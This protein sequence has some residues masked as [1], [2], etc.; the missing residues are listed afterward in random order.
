VASVDKVLGDQRD[1]QDWDVWSLVAKRDWTSAYRLVIRERNISRRL[2]DHT[3]DDTFQRSGALP[4][5]S[6]KRQV[7]PRGRLW[8][9]LT[10]LVIDVIRSSRP[11][12]ERLTV[13]VV[14]LLFA[15]HLLVLVPLFWSL[16]ARVVRCSWSACAVRHGKLGTGLGKAGAGV[17]P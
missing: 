3:G 1:L 17:H 16:A 14:L 8:C 6:S 11:R 5:S 2:L 13:R 12:A 9:F 10:V 7:L 4:D 15:G